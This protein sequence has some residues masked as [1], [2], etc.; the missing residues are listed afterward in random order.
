MVCASLCMTAWWRM[1]W[2]TLP[3]LPRISAAEPIQ[4]KSENNFKMEL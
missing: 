3:V 2:M 4:M 1:L